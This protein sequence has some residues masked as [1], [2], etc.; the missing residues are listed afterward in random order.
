MILCNVVPP[1]VV[2]PVVANLPYLA[3]DSIDN[4]VIF[5]RK[6][7]PG[8]SEHSFGIHVAQMAGMPP[9]VVKRAGEVLDE[10]ESNSQKGS[11][12]RPVGDIGQNREGY[13]LSFFQL[14]D[15]VLQQ[16]RDQILNMN[17]DNLTPVDALNKLNE[18]K[19]IAGL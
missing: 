9:S 4:R 6:L 7:E 19:R 14:D 5:L 10:L 8:G 16:I 13:Q 2:D 12:S 1:R 15:P 17:I 18:I 3:G 11:V